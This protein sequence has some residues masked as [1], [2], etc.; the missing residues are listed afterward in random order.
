MKMFIILINTKQRH[1]RQGVSSNL[2]IQKVDGNKSCTCLESIDVEPVKKLNSAISSTMMVL[3]GVLTALGNVITS[4]RRFGRS[5]LGRR[6]RFQ[7]RKAGPTQPI[8]PPCVPASGLGGNVADDFPIPARAFA[9]LDRFAVY[10]ARMINADTT[11][12]R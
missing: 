3:W 9:L 4:W 2:R 6:V 7:L 8:R 10:S 1:T 5:L 12:T 11:A